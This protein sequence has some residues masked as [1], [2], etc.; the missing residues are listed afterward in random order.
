MHV[1]WS[2]NLETYFSSFA[3]VHTS[4]IFKN[5]QKQTDHFPNTF[6]IIRHT[7]VTNKNCSLKSNFHFYGKMDPP[8]FS[9]IRSIILERLK[10]LQMCIISK[11][12]TKSILCSSFHRRCRKRCL[13]RAKESEIDEFHFDYGILLHHHRRIQDKRNI[14]YMTHATKGES[15]RHFR[16]PVLVVHDVYLFH[17]REYEQDY[18]RWNEGITIHLFILPNHLKKCKNFRKIDI[19][20][21]VTAEFERDNSTRQGSR[22]WYRVR[23]LLMQK[24][25][26]SVSRTSNIFSRSRGHTSLFLSV[27][28]TSV[29]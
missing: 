5:Y 27:L 22:V 13:E 26:H 8:I 17:E 12:K 2:M 19:V 20:K 28:R 9:R 7:F 1:I 6:S 4:K 23:L 21:I 3:K 25:T 15:V 14:R 10:Y 24:S 18:F 29:K 11:V 16:D